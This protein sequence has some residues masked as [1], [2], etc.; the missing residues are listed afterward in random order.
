LNRDWSFSQPQPHFCCW[1]VPLRQAFVASV[2]AF[3]EPMPL[4]I[5][6]PAQ[7]CTRLTAHGLEIDEEAT[8]REYDYLW[9]YN[10]MDHPVSVPRSFAKI[11]SS[12]ATSLWKVRCPGGTGAP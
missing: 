11:C 3:P 6:R 1:A 7:Q 9:I 2:W 8:R 4:T 12:G 10:P 5:R